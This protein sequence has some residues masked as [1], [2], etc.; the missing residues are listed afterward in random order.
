MGRLTVETPHGAVRG[1]ET[2]HGLVWKGI[3]FAAPPVG[4]RRFSPP[5]PPRAWTGVR[6]A[7]EFAPM[8]VQPDVPGPDQADDP[9]GDSEDCL[10]LNVWAPATARTRRPVLVWIHGGGFIMGSGSEYDGGALAS[11]GDVVVVT[12]N[13]RLGPWGF[14]H[15]A[16]LGLSEYADSAN[17][18]LRDLVAA[19]AWVR[20]GIEAFGGDP[21]RVSVAGQSAGAML[22][23]ALLG[24]PAASG[25]FQRAILLSG[26]AC[27][28]R[29]REHGSELARRLLGELGM[30]PEHAGRLRDLPVDDLR[31][32]AAAVRMGVVGAGLG[33]EAFLPIID[34]A[35]LPRHPMGAV[36]S[37]ATRD[38]PLLIGWCREEMNAFLTDGPDSRV[39]AGREAYGRRVMGEQAWARLT[40]V[41]RDTSPPCGDP[42]GDLLGDAMFGLP[43]VRLAEEQGAGGGQAWLMRY[44]HTPGTAPFDRLGPTHGAEL[45]C[46]WGDI[47]WFSALPA[48]PETTRAP[49][50]D[51]DRTVAVALQDAVLAFARTGKPGHAALPRWPAYE[52][53]RRS[54]L[55]LR[56]PL[57][58]VDD[59]ASERRR[60]WDCLPVM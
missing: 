19:L 46:L 54:T 25:L 51:D 36:G 35:V 34:G 24:M 15:L 1:M 12:V 22:I 28:V 39:P 11:R 26:A 9:P 3:P 49:M 57:A 23:G 7:V 18:A 30:A 59:P 16:D 41:Y 50:T 60:A 8:A 5:L 42:R 52:R 43:A 14:L 37:G 33:P 4:V 45:P 13:Y 38:V 17:P 58:L 53:G 44:D 2:R 20:D 48:I 31:L 40:A 47:P 29:T 32:A 55:L 21:H 6:D 56:A 10:Y 27:H